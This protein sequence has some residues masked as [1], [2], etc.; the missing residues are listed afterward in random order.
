LWIKHQ[1]WLC[2]GHVQLA[3]SGLRQ[4]V[5]TLTQA[6]VDA[7]ADTAV[8]RLQQLLVEAPRGSL[9]MDTLALQL[10]APWVRY[11]IIPWQDKLKRPADWENYAKVAMSQQYGVGTETWRV[12][13]AEGGWGKPRLAAAIEQ[14]LYQ[15]MVE[16]ARGQKLRLTQVEPMLTT[17]I[18]RHKGALKQREFTLLLIDGEQAVCA[19]W[20][21]HAWRGVVT[22]PLPPEALR[23]G[24][25]VAALIRD[26]AMMTSD[27]LPEQVYVVASEP[28][29]ARM[30]LADFDLQWLG[31][32]HPLF[33]AREA[34]A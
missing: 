6:P 27:F 25:A 9:R 1:A 30:E 33:T 12:R 3:S 21:Q 10:G 22:L 13:V 31:P 7:A 17:A 14:G 2:L 20:R 4:G 15:T 26:A 8:L 29:F 5:P 16:L 32:V 23:R 28:R 19:F 11:A 24:E 34:N 18:N